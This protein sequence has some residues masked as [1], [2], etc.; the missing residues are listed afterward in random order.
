MADLLPRG[1]EVLTEAVVHLVSVFRGGD[2]RN[3]EADSRGQDGCQRDLGSERP[4]KN[5]AHVLL[6]SFRM[7]ER[8]ARAAEEFTLFRSVERLCNP[9]ARMLRS[10]PD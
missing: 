6:L 1:R 10:T 5:A 8:L 7:V 9:A 4:V 2:G 3:G